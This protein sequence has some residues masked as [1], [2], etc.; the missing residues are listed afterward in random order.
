MKASEKQT[1]PVRTP[2]PACNPDPEVGLTREQAQRRLDA[3]WG[4]AAP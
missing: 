2:L 3:G 4:N 1:S